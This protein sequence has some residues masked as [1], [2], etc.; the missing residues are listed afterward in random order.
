MSNSSQPHR[1]QHTRLPCPS[2][3]LGVCSSS[4]PSSQ[5][6]P[7]TISSSVAPFSSCP[8]SFPTLDCFPPKMR[9]FFWQLP[10]V[11][12]KPGH[13]ELYSRL[14]VQAK[15]SIYL[16]QIMYC[17]GH[18]TF[19]EGNSTILLPTSAKLRFR[20][21]WCLIL[22]DFLFF[23]LLYIEGITHWSPSSLQRFIT[24]SNWYCDFKLNFLPPRYGTVSRVQQ[25]TQEFLVLVLPYHQCFLLSLCFWPLLRSCQFSNTITKLIFNCLHWDGH[26][27]YLIFQLLKMQVPN[28]LSS[29]LQAAFPPTP[30][31]VV[32][33]GGFLF[34]PHHASP[35]TRNWNWAPG[36]E[37]MES[38]P[39]DGQGF[40]LSCSFQYS[41]RCPIKWSSLV[42]ILFGL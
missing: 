36:S 1:L 23:H 10:G 26:W 5:W 27:K 38:Q 7:P 8:Q 29:P 17:E 18:Y 2:P 3:S 34:L 33:G 31:V 30:F 28:S 32:V 42:I 24:A 9:I 12:S 19:S 40:P 20:F 21:L 16:D 41:P 6:C 25:K 35:L 13:F 14:K 4:C 11:T 22:C 15:C 37:N 39:L